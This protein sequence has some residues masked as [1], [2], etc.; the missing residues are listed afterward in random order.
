[1]L[2]KFAN[3]QYVAENIREKFEQRQIPNK[4]LA[5]LYSEYNPKVN[6]DVF[7][8]E[9][10]KIFPKLNC[11][12]TSI[13]LQQILGGELVWGKYNEHAHSFLLLDGNTIVDI[14]ADQYGGPKVYVG[15]LEFPWSKN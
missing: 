5:K 15:R 4:E 7:I 10:V 2:N 1:M 13:Y 12:L 3:I 6:K 14:T 8:T 11:G 9:A